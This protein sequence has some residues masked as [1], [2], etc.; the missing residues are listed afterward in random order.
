M[1]RGTADRFEGI[2][3]IAKGR[4]DASVISGEGRAFGLA[5]IVSS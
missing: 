4:F 1:L 5:G 2:D 3:L